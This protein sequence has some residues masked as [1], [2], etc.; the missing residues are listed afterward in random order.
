MVSIYF[1]SQLMY[2]RQFTGYSNDWS[3]QYQIIGGWRWREI[4]GWWNITIIW[5]QSYQLVND[6]VWLL[7]RDILPGRC[8][9]HPEWEEHNGSIFDNAHMICGCLPWLWSTRLFQHSARICL[10][11]L[12]DECQHMGTWHVYI[13]A[14]GHIPTVRWS[15]PAIAP[16]NPRGPGQT[17]RCTNSLKSTRIWWQVGESSGIGHD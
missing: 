16:A 2:A 3:S 14:Y 5:L 4:I 8:W 15:F 6:V 10:E 12:E 11:D 7:Q 13:P 1:I 9:G 17:V